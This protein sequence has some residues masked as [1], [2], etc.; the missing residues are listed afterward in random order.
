V[1]VSNPLPSGIQSPELGDG[2]VLVAITVPKSPISPIRAHNPINI[3]FLFIDISMVLFMAA[4][5]LNTFLETHRRFFK[6]LLHA[7]KMMFHHTEKRS[8]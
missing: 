4:F 5:T 7:M 1:S 2:P 6:N 8:I 3:V